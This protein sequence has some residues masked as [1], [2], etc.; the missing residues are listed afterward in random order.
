MY[1]LILGG[2]G[3]IGLNYIIKNKNKKII[4]VDNQSYAANISQLKY[5]KRLPNFKYFKGNISNQKILIDI[6]NKYKIKN[7]INFAAETHVDNSISNPKIFV[8]KNVNDFVK[9][10]I[11]LT[12]IINKKELKI[13]YLHIS[14][15]EVYG[16]LGINQKKF[17]ETNKFFPNSPYSASKASAENF[18]RAWGETFGLN[19]MIVNPSNNFGQYQDNE[20]FIPTI[21]NSLIQKKKIP[22]YGDGSNI[23]DW[24]FVKD[25]CE[26]LNEILKKGKNRQSYNIGGNNEMSNLNLVKKICL[27]FNNIDPNYDYFKLINF[28]KDRSGHDFRYGI[29]NDKTKKLIGKKFY[30]SNFDK[31]LLNTINWYLKNKY[32]FVKK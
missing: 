23:R 1:S 12:E 27:I 15:D 2:L 18:L 22:I 10:L 3:F 16:S 30:K 28:V 31:N 4:C 17:I 19:Y 29:N 7:I 13:K 25:H 20:K 8:K 26:I 11:N 21:I 5:L 9:F 24:L 14:T 32:M 6:F